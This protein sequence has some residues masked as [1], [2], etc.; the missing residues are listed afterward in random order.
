MSKRVAVAKP[1]TLV[2]VVF[3]I[4]VLIVPLGG[5]PYPITVMVDIVLY[6]MITMGL[7]MLMGQAGQIS[8]GH[9]AFYGIGAYTSA[10]LTAAPRY[11]ALI[12]WLP[13][14]PAKDWLIS[15]G[16]LPMWAG[17]LI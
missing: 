5:S 9:A 4:A 10:V 6:S 1:Q 17:L 14:L 15:V 11:K 13:F 8:L 3:A 7:V 12:E 16:P 2:I